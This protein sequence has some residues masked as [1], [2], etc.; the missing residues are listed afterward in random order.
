LTKKRND[1][2]ANRIYVYPWDQLSK[3]AGELAVA[4]GT[5]K[6]K[7]KESRYQS[8][9]GDV[10]VNWGASDFPAW[11]DRYC[12]QGTLRLNPVINRVLDKKKFFEVVSESEPYYIPA[13]ACSKADAENRLAFPVLCRTKLKG[14]DGQGIVIAESKDQLVEAPLYVEMVK[15]TAEYRVHVGTD[16]AGET[17]I[18][19]AQR[20]FRPNGFEGEGDPRIRT[21]SNGCYFVWTVNNVAVKDTL[22]R[23]VK[24]AAI[25]V[26]N[27]FPELDFGGLDIIYDKATDRAYALEIN[28]APELTDRTAKMYAEFFEQFT[29]EAEEQ[30][31]YRESDKDYVARNLEKAVRLLEAADVPREAFLT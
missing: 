10:I 3:S 15:Q 25:W 6:I 8:R 27:F 2:V 14:H 20:K 31:G 9:K 7:R 21:T 4:L 18:I 23:A 5:S 29:R 1:I 22:P 17:S 19:G 30:V 12:T 16:K 28:T 11:A 13:H 24:A 26:F